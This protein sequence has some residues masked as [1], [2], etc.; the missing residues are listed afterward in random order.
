MRGKPFH[1]SVPALRGC[2]HIG[3][4]FGSASEVSSSHNFRLVPKKVSNVDKFNLFKCPEKL[5]NVLPVT[6]FFSVRLE[7]VSQI[8]HFP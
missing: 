8:S 3:G 6:F 2:L 1:A 4:G 7:T 5:E